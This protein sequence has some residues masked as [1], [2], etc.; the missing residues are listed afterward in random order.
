MSVITPL[1]VVR[2]LEMESPTHESYDDI[3]EALSSI[4]ALSSVVAAALRQA[5][6]DVALERV[7]D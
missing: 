5:G 3:E 4:P 6:E 7:P 1:D 2:L